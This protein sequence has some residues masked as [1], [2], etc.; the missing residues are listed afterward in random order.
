MNVKKD[1]ISSIGLLVVSGFI[2]LLLLLTPVHLRALV[3]QAP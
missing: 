1:E 3:T 2:L